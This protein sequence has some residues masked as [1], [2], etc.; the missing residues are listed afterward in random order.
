MLGKSMYGNAIHTFSNICN[1]HMWNMFTSV[2]ADDVIITLISFK[3]LN[4]ISK[5]S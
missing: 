5:H 4:K 2:C 3:T 1:F